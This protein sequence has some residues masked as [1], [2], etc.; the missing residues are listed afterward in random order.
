MWWK[1]FVEEPSSASLLPR[2]RL[3]KS[4]ILSEKQLDSFDTK[5]DNAFNELS[6]VCSD[7]LK[8]LADNEMYFH[9]KDR[10]ETGGDIMKDITYEADK[11]FEKN[12]EIT[13]KLMVAER[14]LSR[15]NTQDR[16][17]ITKTRLVIKPTKTISNIYDLITQYATS[18]EDEDEQNNC[19]LAAEILNG[20][21][22]LLRLKLENAKNYFNRKCNSM[23]NRLNV[24][25]K[26]AVK[27]ASKI[28]DIK[29]DV[30]ELKRLYPEPPIPG[31]RE[32][33]KKDIVELGDTSTAMKKKEEETEALKEKQLRITNEITEMMNK[34]SA[35]ISTMCEE[36]LLQQT[37]ELKKNLMTAQ[38]EENDLQQKHRK[39]Q[40]QIKSTKADI[41]QIG[42][43]IIQINGESETLRKAIAA[44]SEKK[45]KKESVDRSQYSQ[46]DME[47]LLSVS[48]NPPDEAKLNR[49]REEVKYKKL[50]QEV[51]E[52]KI[53]EMKKQISAFDDKIA[54]MEALLIN[55]N[56]SSS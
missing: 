35:E 2:D 28:E 38:L 53:E 6:K 14:M 13:E 41:M 25:V 1:R 10:H 5:Y 17:Q 43:R 15:T 34:S 32:M 19:I 8:L 40:S 54:K 46:E 24:M 29:C 4:L 30:N 36:G 49:L 56:A 22:R 21:N 42:E 48:R 31:L 3:E 44:F 7:Y 26:K 50:Q 52:Q 16:G 20:D 23:S 12:D 51:L 37:I 39:M 33:L 27:L 11:V 55:N 9:D 47:Y 45:T 18:C